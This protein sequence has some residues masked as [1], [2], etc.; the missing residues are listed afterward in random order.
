MFLS[1]IVSIVELLALLK[2]LLDP[3][4]TTN[5]HRLHVINN[6]SCFLCDLGVKI[7]M[8]NNIT[9]RYRLYVR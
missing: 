7:C 8:L 9:F 4:E 6:I 2:V 5:V 1:F 3:I